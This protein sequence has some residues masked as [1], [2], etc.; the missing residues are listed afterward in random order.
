[1]KIGKK[2]ILY[3]IIHPENGKEQNIVKDPNLKLHFK[4]WNWDSGKRWLFHEF[5]N[6]SEACEVFAP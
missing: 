6:E 4:I 1:M 5:D 3:G 2:G